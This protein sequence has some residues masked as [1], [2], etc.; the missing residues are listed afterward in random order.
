M[1]SRMAVEALRRG[2]ERAAL[3]AAGQERTATAT[4]STRRAGMTV[5]DLSRLPVAADTTVL[6]T[7]GGDMV[8]L[9]GYSAVGGPDVLA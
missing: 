6:Q 9:A 8:F 7:S 5:G 1:R 3:R 4:S 2:V